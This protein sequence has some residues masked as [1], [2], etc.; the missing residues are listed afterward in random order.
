MRREARELRRIRVALVAPF[1]TSFGSQL[2]RDILL[3]HAFTDAGDGWGECVALAAPVYS[4][5]YVDGAQHAIAHHLLPRLFAEPHL[6]AEKVA[7][8]LR[9]VPGHRM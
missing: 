2:E 3:V 6:T 4:S 5:E 7:E 1:R 9:P 8:V